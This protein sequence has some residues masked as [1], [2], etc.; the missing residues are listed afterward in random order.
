MIDSA[1][2][3]G[4]EAGSIHLLAEGLFSKAYAFT[5]T[6]KEYVIRLNSAAHAEESFAKDAYAWRHF[7]SDELPVPQV[8]ATGQAATG[9]YAISERSPGRS[10]WELSPEAREPLL[11]AFL[12]T[13]EAVGRA[14]VSQ[15]HGY[16]Y[17]GCD[18]NGQ[19]ASWR[20]Y[21]EDATQDEAG[22][23]QN[24]S[25]LYSESFLEREIYET[26]CRRMLELTRW[27]P[28]QRSLVHGDYMF[29]NLVSDG[30]RITGVIDWALSLFGDPLY[31]VAFLTWHAAH[32]GWWYANGKEIIR[33]RFGSAANYAERIACYQC[34]IG[35]G[36]LRFYATYD[37]L[38]DYRFCRDWLLEIVETSESLL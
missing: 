32:P 34:H 10:M 27:C 33:S 29:V 12:D 15:S 23:H 22:N 13:L 7:A 31:D 38:D 8:L 19:Y 30:E 9:R 6:G 36:L 2:G 20:D 18:G 14:N 21:L 24:V 25:R 4:A 35:L 37:M 28:D 1:F 17:W 3:P 5:V 26:V 16:G 11:P